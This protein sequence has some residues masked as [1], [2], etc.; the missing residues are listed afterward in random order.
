MEAI[1][2]AIKKVIVETDLDYIKWD[3]N[4]NI[5]EAYSPYLADE[6]IPQTEFFH[7]YILGSMPFIR[8]NINRIS[9]D[10]DRRLCWRRRSL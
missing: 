2:H 3:M 4:R 8:K 6:G 9:G 5:T 10:F 7:R 1:F